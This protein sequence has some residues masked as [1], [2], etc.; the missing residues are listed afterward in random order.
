MQ[1]TYLGPGRTAWPSSPKPAAATWSRWT[2]P[3]TAAAATWR[4]GQWK[5]CSPAPAAAPPTTWVLI[6]KRGRHDVRG[7]EVRLEAERGR[8]RPEGL[9][10]HRAEFRRSRQGPAARGGRSGGPLVAR[11]ILLGHGH[12]RQDGGDRHPRRGDRGALSGRGARLCFRRNA[13]LS[14]ITLAARRI[15]RPGRQRQ[16]DGRPARSP[17]AHAAPRRCASARPPR[18]RLR[19]KAAGGRVA[20]QV[21]LDLLLRLG[22]ETEAHAV[23][24]AR[25][26]QAD[27]EGAA[28]PRGLS[29]LVR[30]PSSAIRRPVQ[31]RWSVSSRAASANALAQT[32]IRRTSAWPVQAPARRPPLRGR[33][34]SAPPPPRALRGSVQSYRR[35]APMPGTGESLPASKPRSAAPDR[36]SPIADQASQGVGHR[37][38]ASASSVAPVPQSTLSP[39]K[40]DCRTCNCAEGRA[41]LSRKFEYCAP[42]KGEGVAQDAQ[43]LGSR[44]H[45]R[46][47]SRGVCPDGDTTA[48]NSTAWST[49]R[50]QNWNIDNGGRSRLNRISSG[51]SNR[52]PLGHSRPRRPWRRLCGAVHAR[53][54]GSN[55]TPAR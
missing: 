35:H 15:A 10:P 28:V 52:F 36:L 23:A 55:S 54:A 4:R 26:E 49:L 50:L 19:R 18:V 27:G 13:P 31:A 2:A 22:H 48:S 11:E 37:Y 21:P 9:H 5:W 53:K 46:S 25:R 7:C 3:P 16:F 40:A 29:R 51:I 24:H 43:E 8:H 45:F 39:V 33:P 30:P 42:K 34:A 20:L 6:L 38:L 32:R 17:P 44:S 14:S 1:A 41:I 47:R 12:A